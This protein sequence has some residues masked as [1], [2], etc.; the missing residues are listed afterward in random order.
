MRKQRFMIKYTMGCCPL[1]CFV[2]YLKPLWCYCMTT[3]MLLGVQQLQNWTVLLREFS[4]LTNCHWHTVKSSL[5]L[6]LNDI[7]TTIAIKLFNFPSLLILHNIFQFLKIMLAVI[8]VIFLSP[9]CSPILA[10]G[11]SFT[12]SF[13]M[14]HLAVKCIWGCHSVII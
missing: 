11:V 12:G 3:V 13:V 8:S 10:R 2:C 7:T 9:E 14:E 5:L 1:Q 6:W 4:S